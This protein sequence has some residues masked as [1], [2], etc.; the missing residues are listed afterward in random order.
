M[1]V[2]L[3]CLHCDRIAH[4]PIRLGL[5]HQAD[6]FGGY[7]FGFQRLPPKRHPTHTGEFIGSKLG[8]G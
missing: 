6:A 5:D 8:P 1:T 3:V 7:Q 2:L 4:D